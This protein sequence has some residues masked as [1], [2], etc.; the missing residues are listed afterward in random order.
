[1]VADPRS[2]PSDWIVGGA[3]A[4]SPAG[5]LVPLPAE[6]GSVDQAWLETVVGWSARGVPVLSLGG[7]PP[8]SVRVYLDGAV[9][10]P[11]PPLATLPQL[12]GELGGLP[13]LVPAADAAEAVAALAAGASAV[14]VPQPP[15]LWRAELVDLVEEPHPAVA[16]GVPL[17]TAMRTADLASVVGLPRGFPGGEVVLPSTWYAAARLVGE[18]AQ[19]LP[20]VVSHESVRVRVPALAG[21]GLLVVTRP[22]EGEGRVELVEVQGERLPTAAE[23]LARHQ[24]A[25]ARLGRLVPFWE[26][27]QRLLVRVW[28]GELGRSFEVELE[29]PVFW[30][31][32]VGSDWEIARAWVDGVAWDPADLPELPLLEP[33]RPPVPPLALRLDPA[34][35][36][37]LEGVAQRAGR[38]CY[39][40]AFRQVP[41]A[42]GA[43]RS[44]TA[45]IDAES[46]ALVELEE[47]ALELPGDVRATRSVSRL[48]PSQVDGETVWLPRQVVADD[49]LSVFGGS[50]TVHRQLTLTNLV[51][52]PSSFEIDRSAAYARP[53]RML[54]ETAGGVVPLLPDGRGGRTVGGGRDVSHTF[55]IGGVVVDPGLDFPVPFGGLQIQDYAFRGRNEQLRAL[56]AGAI[57]D[58]AW[59]KRLD[60]SELTAR[61]F[62]Q[63]YPFGNSVWVAGEEREGETVEVLHQRLGAGF[64]RTLGATRWLLDVGLDR[65]DFRRAEETAAA[66]VLP[67]DTLEGRVRLETRTVLGATTVTV[68]GEAGWRQ[69]WEAWGMSAENPPQRH[70]R[71]IQLGLVR[72]TTPFPLAKL[73]LRAELATGSHLDRFSA[74]SPGRFGGAKVLG[75]ASGRVLPERLVVAGGSLALPVGPRLRARMGADVAWVWEERSGYSARLLSGVGVALSAKGPWRTMLEASASYP[76]ATPGPRGAVVELFL[77]RPL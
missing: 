73:S 66:F 58:A 50:A 33:E 13:V 21:G 10:E 68:A 22:G 8:E 7:L 32:G 49:L 52:R 4:A 59:T 25:A 69:R 11:A 34:W 43:K 46:F 75:I 15:L 29:G 37:Q 24:R 19:E 44:G 2:G 53:L 35:V 38:R 63:L 65:W 60:G 67:Q 9:L 14:L 27:T 30:A 51:P 6:S 47:R 20:V 17:A 12:R 23:V 55:L 72:E 36:F 26:A 74:P 61:A 16:A 39:A 70:W 40:L 76:L 45:F 41:S 54:R 31:E 5:V 62:L 18:E 3:E 1:V 42:G 28:V 77:L 56:I 64:A 48:A 57:N 71:Q